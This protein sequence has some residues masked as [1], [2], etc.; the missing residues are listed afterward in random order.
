MSLESEKRKRIR[1]DDRQTNGQMDKWTEFPLIDSTP[2][3]GRV[4]RC[5]MLAQGKCVE[6]SLCLNKRWNITTD[7]LT[8][9]MLTFLPTF[10]F[11]RSFT[12]LDDRIYI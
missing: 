7:L 1:S 4:K 12:S 6:G 5:K 11:V 10:A 8:S 9:S 3:R 2:E